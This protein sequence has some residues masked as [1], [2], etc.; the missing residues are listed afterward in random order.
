MDDFIKQERIVKFKDEN[1]KRF[2]WDI[3]THCNY[4]CSYCYARADAGNWLK[5]SR[6]PILDKVISKMKKINHPIDM[7]L[8]GGEPTLHP[9][10][11]N[12]LEELDNIPNVKSIRILSNGNYGALEKAK[13]FIDKHKDI[14]T[15]FS[16]LLTYHL[17]EVNKDN[18]FD[19]LKYIKSQ[20]YYLEVNLLFDETT[21]DENLI[22]MKDVQDLDIIVR[23]SLIFEGN[24][25]KIIP[26]QD[27]Q[28][29]RDKILQMTE[30]FKM[31]EEL[32]FIRKDGSYEIYNDFNLY[33]N[34]F[35]G[36]KDWK[37]YMSEY[38][39]PVESSDIYEFCSEKSVNI[40]YVNNNKF[41]IC[42]L[43]NCI[44]PGKISLLK[45]KV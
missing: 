19:T 37:C 36:F 29:F 23:P 9:K 18:F 28:E 8:L 1:L 11:F 3:I 38:F 22:I 21:I 24:D 42:P 34:N 41:L 43:E 39:I 26:I 14:K 27:E 44:C 25:F 6:K 2:N 16:F 15:P 13:V 33:L 7:I 35:K 40:D 31:R 4:H 45:E 12:I 32:K 10:Y 5:M 17:T 20:N 30:N